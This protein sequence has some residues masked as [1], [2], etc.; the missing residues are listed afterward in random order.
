MYVTL[1]F[2][3]IICNRM[4]NIIQKKLFCSFLSSDQLAQLIEHETPTQET[5]VQISLKARQNF[6]RCKVLYKLWGFEKIQMWRETLWKSSLIMVYVSYYFHILLFRPEYSS[7]AIA[8]LI[9]YKIPTQRT[10]VQL[11]PQAKI[12]SWHFIQSFKIFKI[13]TWREA[14]KILKKEFHERHYTKPFITCVLW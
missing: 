2:N 1:L 4:R 10:R 9:E 5:R 11:P 7:E 8:Q 6:F 3:Y 13:Q 14:L 12:F